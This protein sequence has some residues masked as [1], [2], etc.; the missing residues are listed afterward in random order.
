MLAVALGLDRW[1]VIADGA[2]VLGLLQEKLGPGLASKSWYL[3][4]ASGISRPN[5]WLGVVTLAT[6]VAATALGTWVGIRAVL[7]L[8]ALRLARLLPAAFAATTA[9][10]WTFAHTSYAADLVRYARGDGGPGLSFWM[11]LAAVP[12]AL[13]AWHGRVRE[14]G[15]PT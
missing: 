12:I 10:A 13:L 2:I 14:R 15:G 7:G 1:L 11:S 4:E 9:L 5:A 8:H 6:A 3:F